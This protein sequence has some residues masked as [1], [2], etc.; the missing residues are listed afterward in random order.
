MVDRHTGD[1]KGIGER[2]AGDREF[3][4]QDC[5]PCRQQGERVEK[6]GLLPRKTSLC[7]SAVDS[8]C[9]ETLPLNPQ[10]WAQ[11][12]S[13]PVGPLSEVPCLPLIDGAWFAVANKLA[14]V[15]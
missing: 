10:N 1:K 8:G 2:H 12:I 7:G 5:I 4:A 6:R 11:E 15:C 9:S 13:R 3:G 14:D